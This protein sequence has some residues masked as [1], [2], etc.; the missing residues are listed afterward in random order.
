MVK[1]NDFLESISSP[2]RLEQFFKLLTWI[3]AVIVSLINGNDD[4]SIMVLKEALNNDLS[5]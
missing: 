5:C 2:K 4:Y 1:S 3:I